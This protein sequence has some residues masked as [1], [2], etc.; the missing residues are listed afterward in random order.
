MTLFLNIGIIFGQTAFK[1]FKKLE[2]GKKVDLSEFHIKLDA[3]HF[4]NLR[5]GYFNHLYRIKKISNCK[6]GVVHN[7]VRY[8]LYKDMPG[9]VL[10]HHT[11]QLFLNGE[12]T[13]IKIEMIL[14]VQINVLLEPLLNLRKCQS[15]NEAL[16]NWSLN[17]NFNDI[18]FIEIGYINHL[19]LF[20]NNNIEFEDTDVQSILNT[21]LNCESVHLIPQRFLKKVL[22][23]QKKKDNTHFK[24][25]KFMDIITFTTKHF[26]KLVRKYSKFE[27]VVEVT[28]YNLNFPIE[29]YINPKKIECKRKSLFLFK[30]NN[31]YIRLKSFAILHNLR[32]FF[33][34]RYNSKKSLGFDGEYGRT[35][36]G[37]AQTFHK[38]DDVLLWLVTHPNTI[39]DVE[40]VILDPIP[41]NYIF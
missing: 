10:S 31:D 38:Y 14:N 9:V 15:L 1:I 36:N 13:L 39:E 3:L 2:T 7:G 16:M 19:K 23:L 6:L 24:V 34:T 25:S 37:Y 17:N 22:A 21:F 28:R 29:L 30:R 40:F 4:N 32:W 12:L 26:I 27:N 20:E 33:N 35:I 11:L 5:D 41:P 18:N 8:Y